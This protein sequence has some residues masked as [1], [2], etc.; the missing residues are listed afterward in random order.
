MNIYQK[1]AKI[2][3]IVDVL[4]ATAEGHGYKYVPEA[5]IV[6]KLKGGMQKYHISLNPQI[7][8]GS[9]HV[10]PRSFTKTRITRTGDRY[11]ESNQ[12][13][14]VY[15]DMY[16]V[17][18]NDDNPQEYIKIPWIAIGHQSN[19]SHAFGSGLTYSARYFYLKYFNIATSEDDPDYL[20]KK[21]SDA[22]AAEDKLVLQSI[23]GEIDQVVQSHVTPENRSGL[24]KLIGSMVTMNGKSMGDYRKIKHIDVAAKVL[25]AV[26]DYFGLNKKSDD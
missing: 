10:I 21:R 16:W 13:V 6:S 8:H 24:Q 14:L 26:C 4:Q 7:V 22:F 25:E 5:E 15:C 20:E 18:I 2:R 17:W 1:L 11:E 19:A 23:I 12:D 3:S 9:L